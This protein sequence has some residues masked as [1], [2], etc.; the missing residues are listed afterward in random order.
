MRLRVP[1]I[2]VGALPHFTLSGS[3][4][5]R[6]GSVPTV[7]VSWYA[8]GGYFAGPQVIGIGEGRY[9]EVALP[10]SPRVLAGIGR[11]V[12]ESVGGGGPSVEQTFNVYANDP[13]L[14]AAK[15][16]RRQKSAWERVSA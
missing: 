14:V 7:G 15:V 3:F 2:E 12:A 8:R 9:D 1:R 5:A 6:T 11:G 13:D 10:L 16:A 4:D